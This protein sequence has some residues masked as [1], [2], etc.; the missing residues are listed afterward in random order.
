[1][2]ENQ[3]QNRN[4]GLESRGL[5]LTAWGDDPLSTGILKSETL[6]EHGPTAMHSERRRGEEGS[7]YSATGGG[8]RF[9]SNFRSFFPPPLSRLILTLALRLSF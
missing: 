3:N 6:A 9:R 7:I 5:S 1:M 2:D 4:G 8:H